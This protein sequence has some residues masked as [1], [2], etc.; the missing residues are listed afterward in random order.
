MSSQEFVVRIPDLDAGPRRVQRPLSVEWLERALSDA[1]GTPWPA[2]DAP[3]TAGDVDLEVAKSGRQ[4]LVRGRVRARVVL[5]CARTLD[6][7]PYELDAQVFLLL[8]PAQEAPLADPSEGRRRGPRGTRD[9]TSDGPRGGRREARSSQGSGDAPAGNKK[10]QKRRGDWSDDPELT[11]EDAAVDTY[12]G[13]ELVLDDF[14]REFI[15]LEFPM[16]PLREDLRSDAG[17]ASSAL[18]NGAR[19]SGAEATQLGG[20]R[21]VD[22]RLSPLAELKARL[23]K[24]E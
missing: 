22:P 14:I 19:A 16:F 8:H 7:A 3:Q 17:G 4:I 5:A 15:V 13:E 21:P 10:G 24:K 20:D 12:S 9:A 6:P 2:P 1:E 11:D 23:E 18:P